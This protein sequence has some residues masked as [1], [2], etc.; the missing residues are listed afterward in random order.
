MST[1]SGKTIPD[2]L[3][4]PALFNAF[5]IVLVSAILTN[6]VSRFCV[7]DIVVASTLNTTSTTSSVAESFL[8]A[9]TA[10]DDVIVIAPKSTSK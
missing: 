9:V 5:I 7:S 3:S 8:R 10:W 2:I 1:V 4:N 6:F